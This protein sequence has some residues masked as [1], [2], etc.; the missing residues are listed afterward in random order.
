MENCSIIFIL[1]SAEDHWSCGGSQPT[2]TRLIP[3]LTV[4][5]L[6]VLLTDLSLPL[7]NLS[8]SD[9][10]PSRYKP[11]VNLITAGFYLYQ[12]DLG[13]IDKEST[14]PITC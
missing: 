10:I 4:S 3:I 1:T 14:I 13:Y 8:K 6:N 9:I 7:C 2:C 5:I 12:G 11:P